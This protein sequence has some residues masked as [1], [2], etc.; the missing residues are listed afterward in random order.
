MTATA[1]EEYHREFNINDISEYETFTEFD[2]WIYGCNFDLLEIFMQDARRS[3]I[4][5]ATPSF[6]TPW[7]DV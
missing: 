2:I 1:R 5:D 6:T 7:L 4:W 3:V